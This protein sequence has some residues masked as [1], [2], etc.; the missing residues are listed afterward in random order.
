VV[1]DLPRNAKATLEEW[2]VWED[3]MRQLG[4]PLAFAVQD[5]IKPE[6]VRPSADWLFVGGTDEWCY[7]GLR[8]IT[9]MG[10][11]VHVGRV[12][13]I[14]RVQQCDEAGVASVDGNGWFTGD[15]YQMLLPYIQERQACLRFSVQPLGYGAGKGVGLSAEQVSLFPRRP[16]LAPML[17]RWQQ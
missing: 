6:Q 5:R 13:T 12:N 9:S 14:R 1:P 10:K 8:E 15:R 11:Q 4:I 16:D 7:P 3:E 17:K 2:W